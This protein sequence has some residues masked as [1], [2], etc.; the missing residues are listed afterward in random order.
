MTETEPKKQKMYIEK[1]RDLNHDKKLKYY[2]I[3]MGC[4]QNENDSE[5]LCGMIEDMGYTY[6]DKMVLANL[7]VINT[8]CIRESAEEK[9]FGKIGEVK[10][11]KSKNDV[12]LAVGG[13]MMQEEHVLKRLNTSYP[14]VDLIFGTHTLY[15]FS[16]DLYKTLSENKRM[17]DV[18]DVDGEVHEGIPVKRDDKIKANV[19]IMYG[20]NNYCSYCIVPY[21]RGRERSRK[22]ED[23]LA[24]IQNLA[25][26]EYKEITLLGQNVNSYMRNEMCEMRGERYSFA[27][28][29]RDVNKIQGIER[30]RFMSPHPKDFT[31]DLINAIKECDK[32][33][34]NIHLPLQSGSNKI[35]KLMNRK[36]TR[37]DFIHIVEKMKKEIPNVSFSTDIIVGFPEET[38]QNF[39]DT[40]EIISRFKFSQVFMFIFS[41]RVGTVAEKMKNQ[42]PKEIAHKRFDKLKQL[43]ELNL[44]EENSN[45]INTV[46]K[47]L[48]E[49][50]SKT[51]STMLA[52][53]TDSNKIVVFNGDKKLIGSVVDLKIVSQHMYY[54]KGEE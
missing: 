34:K 37:E 42:V 39:N 53:R 38:E 25:K 26:S 21:V 14:F 43:V 32:V 9:V 52:G 49:G 40:L 17:Q 12:I 29:L 27:D 45:Y 3:T 35:L 22:K 23:I 20:C 10:N 1:I 7:I 15:K 44:E 2:I 16:E 48:V 18:L 46:Q 4:K 51:D 54:L 28:L 47:V 11:L 50:K 13:C 8:C 41:P 6:T 24:E 5:K 31:D 36:Y 33:C 30:I 19:S